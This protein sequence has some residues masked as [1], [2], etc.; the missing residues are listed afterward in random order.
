MAEKILGE[1]LLP[2]EAL[3]R[4][5]RLLSDRRGAYA[6]KLSTERKGERTAEGYATKRTDLTLIQPNGKDRTVATVEY[7]EA[8]YPAKLILGEDSGPFLYLAINSAD[9]LVSE[10]RS[11]LSRIAD[12]L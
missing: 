1:N 9:E 11:Y 2:R 3:D 6:A 12:K 5:A 7:P 10:L 4:Q 8:G